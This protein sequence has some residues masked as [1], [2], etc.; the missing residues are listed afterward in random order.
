MGALDGLLIAWGPVQSGAV[1][2]EVAW[3]LLRGIL[4]PGATLSN[5]CPRCGGPHGPVT[6][7][8]APWRAS[9]SYAGGLAVVGIAPAAGIAGLGLDAESGDPATPLALERVLSMSPATL[10]DW[11]RV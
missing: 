5:A 11:T 3:D 1:R 2:R 9:V 7:T 4:P 8:G 10:R 6:V